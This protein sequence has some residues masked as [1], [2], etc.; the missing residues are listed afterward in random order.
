MQT[1]KYIYII[2][3]P[4]CS[5]G[6]E[7]LHQLCDA[8][9]KLGYDA[10]ILYTNR[11]NHVLQAYSKY[12]VKITTSLQSIDSQTSLI[13]LPDC[14]LVKQLLAHRKIYI[15]YKKY[16]TCIYMLSVDNIHPCIKH[17]STYA[18]KCNIVTK[19]LSKNNDYVW[20]LCQSEYANQFLS[21]INLDLNKCIC[22]DYINDIF[23]SETKKK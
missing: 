14:F 19:Y 11:M 4:F 6:P 3:P 23:K 7:A 22:T 17:A 9:N 1:L 10:K 8:L 2:C 16:K 5:G 21:D 15:N 13:V 20:Y 18:E 12:Q